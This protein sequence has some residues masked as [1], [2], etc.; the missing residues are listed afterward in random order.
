MKFLIGMA[1]YPA[2]VLLWWAALVL[3][4]SFVT[5]GG[6]VG[7][8]TGEI[9]RAAALYLALVTSIIAGIYMGCRD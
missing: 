2:Q 9:I 8:L 3:A 1:T 6:P 5:W 7:E 4:H